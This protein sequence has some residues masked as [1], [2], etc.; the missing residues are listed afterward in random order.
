MFRLDVEFTRRVLFLGEKTR[1]LGRVENCR[2]VTRLGEG[3][4]RL[5][6]STNGS[7]LCI[8]RANSRH[9]D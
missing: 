4:F 1:R 5:P 7:T 3:H 6:G 8:I 9:F 2:H